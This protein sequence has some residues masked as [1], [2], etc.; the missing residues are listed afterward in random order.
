[1]Q[2]LSLD[3]IVTIF[4][5]RRKLFALSFAAVFLLA[6]LFA[7]NWSRYRATVTVQIEEPVISSTVAAVGNGDSS[8]GALGLADRRITQIQQKVTS[9]ESLMDIIKQLNLYPGLNKKLAP[10]KLTNAMRNKI[11]LDFVSSTLSNPAAAQKE[12]VEQLSA[13][14]F[15]V[16]FDYSDPKLAKQAL[17]LIVQRFI[18]EEA[19]QRR[20]QG[21]QTTAFLDG[22]IKNLE[23]SIAEQEQKAAQFRAQYGES[24]PSATLFNQQAS[25][26]NALS[27]QTIESQI[28]AAESSV[29]GLRTQLAGT[30]PYSSVTDD[31]KQ[32][33]SA[34]SQLHALES[35][36]AALTARYG[37]EHP[38]V[39]KVKEQIAA[40][41]S[42]HQVDTGGKITRDADNPAYL[43]LNSQLTSAQAQL[44][45]LTGQKAALQAQQ[46]KLDVALAQNPLIEQQM[47]QLTLDLDNA[48]ERYRSLKE[49]RLA[50]EMNTKLESGKNGERL[51]VIIPSILPESTSPKRLYLIIAGLFMAFMSG[52]GMVVIAEAFSQSVRGAHHLTALVG[53]APLVTIPHI[54][55]NP[56]SQ[57]HG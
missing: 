53:V 36:Y 9:I 47:S 28:S 38:D 57:H 42:S 43:Q 7:F 50:A 32:V 6:L 35:Q 48:K 25:L 51:K 16:S 18:D 12:S 3:D 56:A 37:P 29:S 8:T 13:I 44:Q 5:R 54:S 20:E 27:L 46:N 23:T 19:A 45:S 39:I 26:S 34:G 11:N 49:K 4:F 33:L 17:D 55:I 2:D 24:G 10:E 30:S 15:T 41:K 40:L 1:M 31:G 14:A 22:E 52:I 21:E